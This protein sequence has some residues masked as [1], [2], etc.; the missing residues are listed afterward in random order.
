MDRGSARSYWPRCQL[1]LGD[2]VQAIERVEV[3]GAEP[4]AAG[5]KRALEERLGLVV[6][7][8]R[9]VGQAE[10]IQSHEGIGVVKPERG[11][12]CRQDLFVEPFRRVVV[13]EIDVEA[14]Q[15]MHALQGVGMRG[16]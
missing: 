6:L 16:A 12:S 8:V 11:A 10:V 3:V 4:D 13:V 5:I 7:A 14:G 15:V 2:V 1:Q 9:D